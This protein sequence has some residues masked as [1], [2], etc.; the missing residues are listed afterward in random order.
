MKPPIGPHS[1][2]SQAQAQ[3]P[4]PHTPDSQLILCA[5]CGASS[6]KKVQFH[7]IVNGAV[8]KHEVLLHCANPSNHLCNHCYQKNWR[9]QQPKKG[10][11]A[12]PQ[13]QNTPQTGTPQ[14]NTPVQPSEMGGGFV[15]HPL[16][17]VTRD[18]TAPS[19]L[20]DADGRQWEQLSNID[21]FNQQYTRV[22]C[23]TYNRTYFTK[24]FIVDMFGCG[25]DILPKLEDYWVFPDMLRI[26]SATHPL[27]YQRLIELQVYPPDTPMLILATLSGIQYVAAKFE[28][29]YPLLWKVLRQVEPGYAP[30]APPNSGFP[31]LNPAMTMSLPPSAQPQGQPNLNGSLMDTQ[32][33]EASPAKRR[34]VAGADTVAT[35]VQ[36]PAIAQ[37]ATTVQQQRASSAGAFW[38]EVVKEITNLDATMQELRLLLISLQNEVV[39]LRQPQQ[40]SMPPASLQP[41]QMSTVQQPPSLPVPS[42]T[43][44]GSSGMGQNNIRYSSPAYT[45]QQPS[46]SSDLGNLEMLSPSTLIGSSWQPR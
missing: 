22:R 1:S 20:S 10:R 4:T 37:R 36:S 42:L 6:D 16:V 27:D 31:L 13:Q 24:A 33:P 14:Q 28:Q 2:P 17:D 41:Q 46:L 3:T 45:A 40:P 8:G 11:Q 26:T 19:N 38:Q 21:F 12:S 23:A 15:P 44:Y 30:A 29:A 43:S 32:Q 9:M 34:K 5:A 39:S 18:N 35:P 7:R 25:S